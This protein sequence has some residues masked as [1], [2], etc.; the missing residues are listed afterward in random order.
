MTAKQKKFCDYYLALGNATAAAVKA[1]YSKRSAKV[2]GSE[3]LTKPDIKAYIDERMKAAE[4]ERVA[5]VNE[6]LEYLTN[7]MRDNEVPAKE[8]I[9]AA[10][11]L[12]KRYNIFSGD[13][14]TVED[15]SVK[16]DI[17]VKDFTEGCDV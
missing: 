10:E 1:G 5:D 9:R 6:V 16:V 4:S 17:V 7:A 2:I 11:L 15:N 3:N 13:I 14:A 12:G 8:R